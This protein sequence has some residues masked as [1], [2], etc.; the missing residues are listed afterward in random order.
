MTN[1]QLL[2]E[3]G[4]FKLDADRLLEELGLPCILSSFGQVEFTGSY[5]LDLMMNGDIDILVHGQ[6]ERADVQRAL[7]AI[8]DSTRLRGYDFQ[9]FVTYSHPELPTGYYLGLKARVEGYPRLW[10]IDI[11]FLDRN[12]AE[13][14]EYMRLLRENLTP[15][16]KLAILKLKKYRNERLPGILST[17]IYDAVLRHGIMTIKDFKAYLSRQRTFQ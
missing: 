3:S 7:N 2:N 4:R 1:A 13:A 14:Q 17:I 15:E 11:W 10:K 6:F 16:T 5:A 12:R 8:M 9:D